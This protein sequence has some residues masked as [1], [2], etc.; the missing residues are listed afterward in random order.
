MFSST[1]SQKS[2][3]KDFEQDCFSQ[4][5]QWSC[6]SYDFTQQILTRSIVNECA[7]TGSNIICSEADNYC[8][9]NVE[10]IY[11]EVLSRD[12]Y[13]IRELAPDP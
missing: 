6:C 9:E 5:S 8:A 3:L 2:S 11:D 1:G 10:S 13:D 12:E 7:A 4:L